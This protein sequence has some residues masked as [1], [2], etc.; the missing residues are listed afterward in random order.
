[1]PQENTLKHQL[2]IMLFRSFNILVLFVIALSPLSSLQ[3][4]D[5]EKKASA[6][7]AAHKQGAQPTAASLLEDMEKA[8]VYIAKSG[9]T[10]KPVMNPKSKAQRPFWSGLSYVCKHID[11]MK[12]SVK[13]NNV[14]MV[15][16]LQ[17][18]GTGI[19][20]VTTTWGVLRKAH[21]QSGVDAGIGAL[22][23]AYELYLHHYGPAVARYKK[24]GKVT[25]E[26]VA[27]VAKAK[28]ELVKLEAEIKTLKAQAKKNSYEQRMVVDL[29][30]LITEL[31]ALELSNLKSYCK[32]I[33]TWDHFQRIYYGYSDIVEDWYPAFYTHWEV[34][35]TTLETTHKVFVSEESY[36]EGWH[37]SEVAVKDYG[38]YYDDTEI[39]ATVTTEEEESVEATIEHYN[40]EDATEVNS[41]EDEDIAATMEIDEH[42][43]AT[44]ADEV[45]DDLSDGE[46]S[47]DINGDGIGDD[48]ETDNAE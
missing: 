36:Y 37:Y 29:L 22:C 40:E 14:D 7:K 28:S 15:D 31:R 4:K 1:M 11:A 45:E 20:E 26:E 24:G 42:E 27:S 9:L 41:E 32:F 35:T 2:T 8:A 43:D 16:N 17:E 12:K 46:D 47:G 19:T 38:A 23:D 5:K 10:S 21:P 34:V 30:L 48:V 33:Y 25:A 13:T 3:A 18:L 44:L 6:A 39:L